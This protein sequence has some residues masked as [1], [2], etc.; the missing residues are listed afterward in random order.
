MS[1][2]LVQ[3]FGPEIGDAGKLM[4]S[5][6]DKLDQAMAQLETTGGRVQTSE[7]S[8]KALNE[9]IVELTLD[10]AISGLV[11]QYPSLS[12]DAVR[13]QVLTKF[14]TDWKADSS[15]HRTGKGPILSRVKKAV[16]DAAK[17]ELGT[18]NESAAQ[19]A[20]VNTNKER[21]KQQPTPGHG[22]GQARPK[23]EDEIYDQAF[24]E[25]LG[26]EMKR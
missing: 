15:P 9:V 1:D 6:G 26:A 11:G 25:T 8:T 14:E 16:A 2:Q 21:L 13:Q 7:T 20:L 3:D 18:T 5:M 12:K 4:I 24:Q 17:F 23:S 19:V 22:K 10:S